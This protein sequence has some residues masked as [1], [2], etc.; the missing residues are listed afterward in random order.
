MLVTRFFSLALQKRGVG[1]LIILIFLLVY[2]SIKDYGSNLLHGG[3]R[4][5]LSEALFTLIIYALLRSIQKQNIRAKLYALI[6]IFSYY[7]LYEFNFL[8]FGSVLKFSDFLILPELLD[9]LVIYESILFIALISLPV[10]L[11]VS[12]IRRQW[13]FQHMLPSAL[14]V[15]FLSLF[16][17]IPVSMGERINNM[18]PFQEFSHEHVVSFY[19]PLSS[20]LMFEFQRRHNLQKITEFSTTNKQISTKRFTL[21]NKTSPHKNI[22]IIV[23][24]GF[25]DVRKFTAIN[26]ENKFN[27]WF[28]SSIMQY[29]SISIAPGFGNG[30]ARSEFEILCGLPSMQLFGSIEFSIFNGENEIDC[31]P[32][33]FSDA[34]YTT[35]AS[36][37]YKPNYYNRLNAYK[38]IGFSDM[39]FGDKYTKI[40]GAI[41]VDDAPAGW[42][43]DASLYKQNL[44]M[45]NNL[46]SKGQ[47]VF[48]YVLTAYGHY[49]YERD[50]KKRPDILS[51]E[52]VSDE[53]NRLVNQMYYRIKA[54]DHYIKALQVIDPDALIVIVG[55]HLPPLSSGRIKYDKLGYLS[56]GDKINSIFGS[57][58]KYHQSVVK[59]IDGLSSVKLP[60]IHHYDLFQVVL[61]SAFSDEF[62]QLNQCGINGGR[63]N[64]NF[65]SDYVELMKKS[66]IP[67]VK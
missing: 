26:I 55:D 19:G 63:K 13:A 46:M 39:K 28:E 67:T 5:S 65:S 61:N 17:A 15:I 3:F 2:T 64:K 40:Q 41:K 16:S 56:S 44:E 6:P 1:P 49:P 33:I 21:P 29:A 23:L 31:L 42:L 30:T 7:G 12:N 58:D 62:C 45:V 60:S 24:E 48:N 20:A 4:Y 66:L 59:V 52:S 50:E 11:I 18:L 57:A 27:S 34:G 38:T 9:V 43:F 14:F 53:T 51:I 32:K 25:V 54:L 36:H 22:H 10:I 35:V 47:P 8:Q 37:P